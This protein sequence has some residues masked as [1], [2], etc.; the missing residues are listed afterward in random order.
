MFPLLFEVERMPCCVSLLFWDRNY[1]CCPRMSDFKAIIYKIWFWLVLC[2]RPSWGSLLHAPRPLAGFKLR[3]HT[4]VG[5]EGRERKGSKVLL[6]VGPRSGPP[7][8]YCGSTPLF[9]CTTIMDRLKFGHCL[10]ITDDWQKVLIVVTQVVCQS[11]SN[12]HWYG[13]ERRAP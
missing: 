11:N 10:C 12:K 2:P 6:L 1:N 13:S 9:S 8:F 3:G 5:R 7:N 4:S